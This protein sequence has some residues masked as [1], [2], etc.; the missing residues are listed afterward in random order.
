M[1]R[2]K[3]NLKIVSVHYK[4]TDLILKMI[5]KAKIS[6]VRVPLMPISRHH[7]ICQEK[8]YRRIVTI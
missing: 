6:R 7:E 1:T 2:Q 4:N 3:K 8:A 5:K